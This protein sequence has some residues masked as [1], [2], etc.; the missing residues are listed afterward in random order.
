MTFEKWLECVKACL[1]APSYLDYGS[2][3][4]DFLSDLCYFLIQT[5][6]FILS[7][8]LVPFAPIMATVLYKNH[9][10]L[11]KKQEKQREEIIK[12]M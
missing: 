3:L 11:E 9:L 12:R 1:K 2:T 4:S 10:K 7:I 5:L 6:W 8:L